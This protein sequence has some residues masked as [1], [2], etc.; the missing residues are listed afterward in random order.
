MMTAAEWVPSTM[1]GKINMRTL[2]SGSVNGDV[3]PLGGSQRST[4][5]NT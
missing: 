5:A 4:T 2:S 3:K 1:A